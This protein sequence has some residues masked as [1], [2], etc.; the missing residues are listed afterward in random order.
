M[1][2]TP[3]TAHPAII[4][5]LLSRDATESDR[6]R[7]AFAQAVV[8][9]HCVLT[10]LFGPLLA[11]DLPEYFAWLQ[12]LRLDVAD[13]IGALLHVLRDLRSDV[14]GRS[15]S[16]VSWLFDIFN[17]RNDQGIG[18]DFVPVLLRHLKDTRGEARPRERA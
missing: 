12:T 3:H 6:F 7:K 15:G 4:I 13:E 1:R 17:S 8:A 10:V 16:K 14:L 18:E 9:K 5:L 2:R 11:T